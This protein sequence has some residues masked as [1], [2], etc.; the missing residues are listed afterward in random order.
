MHIHV[1]CTDPEYRGWRWVSQCECHNIR[2]ELSLEG[3]E[4]L[5]L[6]D[7]DLKF[8][9]NRFE[10]CHDDG[11]SEYRF[12][13]QNSDC[14]GCG[15]PSYNHAGGSRAMYLCLRCHIA[16]LS[17]DGRNGVDRSHTF[18]SELFVDCDRIPWTEFYRRGGDS[19]RDSRCN[20]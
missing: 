19:G 16:E 17:L 4:Q 15:N 13:V 9:G 14:L 11:G 10:H 5:E 18:F 3:R 1:G 7:S 8:I 6:G 20:W 12:L 2:T